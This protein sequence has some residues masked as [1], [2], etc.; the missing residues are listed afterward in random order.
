MPR[1][2]VGPNPMDL[3]NK[4]CLYTATADNTVGNY[5]R[6]GREKP[7]CQQNRSPTKGFDIANREQSWLWDFRQG[8]SAN[9]IAS[10]E[11]VNV[12]RVRF[13]VARA[14]ARESSALR[15]IRGRVPWLVPLFPIGPYTPRSSCGHHKPFVA[16]SVLCCMV[17][18]RSGWDDHPAIQRDPQ[19]DPAPEHRPEPLSQDSPRET[20]RGRR[21]RLFGSIHR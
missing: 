10:R 19:T 12:R 6:L 8:V 21:E 17:C 16:G 3:V 18:H 13:G 9:A 2:V 1:V 11:G 4:D 7:I 14:S 20:R 5:Q 15:Q